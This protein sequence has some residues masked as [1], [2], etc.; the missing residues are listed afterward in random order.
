[1]M[2]ER[3]VEATA[4]QFGP[5]GPAYRRLVEPFVERFDELISMVLGPLRMP[6]APL[7]FARFGMQALRSL[8]GL[9]REWFEHEP[10]RALLAGIA[11]HAMLPL[12]A[13]G[14]A[15]FG[16]VLACAGHAVGWPIARGGSSA[17]TAALVAC[18]RE[19]GGE[20]ELGREVTTLATLP[21][22][23]AYILDL[24]PKQVLAVAGDRLPAPYRRRLARF[25]YGPGVFK[26]DWALNAPIPWRDPR[27]AR[28]CTVHLAGSSQEV[29][30]AEA[31][32]HAGVV[33]GRPF[34]LLVQPT[35]FDPTRAPR[36][37]HIAWAYC[38][39]PH[40]SPVDAAAAIEAQ[41]ERHAPGFKD[42]ILARSHRNALD[43]ERHNPNYVGGDINGGVADL[44]QLFFR[45]VARVDPY[46]TPTA[47]I[48]LCSSSTPP[49]GGVHG[50]CGF[51][52][53]QS[54]L[55]RAFG[56]R[57]PARSA[58]EDQRRTPSEI[59]GSP[60]RTWPCATSATECRASHPRAGELWPA[61]IARGGTA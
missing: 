38:H 47:D 15:S 39:V 20:L 9:A 25:R 50:M 18:L 43:M 4:E 5:D 7:L 57:T 24:T 52:A 13:A 3:S 2:L 19:H 54:V 46:S 34:V 55:R 58:R 42:T 61:A 12:D 11:A 6:S 60:P 21:P 41:I 44:R 31:A 49:G 10:G 17:I 8:N 45:P 37:V 26:M 27:C 14:T 23:R 56:R 1:V 53:A 16:L 36:G 30:A 51:W 28:A 29:H 32:V 33:V 48:F 40:G 35:L 22:A 59:E